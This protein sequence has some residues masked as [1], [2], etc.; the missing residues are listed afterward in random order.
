MSAVPA[1]PVPTLIV[2]G[3]G[4][5]AGELLRLVA[6]HP[7]LQLAGVSSESQAGSPVSASF[8]HLAP[9]LRDTPFI[10]Q[11]ELAGQLG[12]ERV[13]IFSAAPHVV[14]AGVVG[15]LLQAAG[16]RGT[17]V[18]VV[19][20]S[21]DFRFRRA[22]EF[23]AVYKSPHGAPQLL[24]QF[25]CALPEHLPGIPAPHVGHPG[26][27]ASA[28][29]AGLVPLLRLR[30]TEGPVY[31]SGVTGSTGAGRTPIATTHHPER[32]SNLFAY[33]PLQHRHTPEVMQICAQ[34]TG[35]SPELYFIPHS[36]PFARGIH[37]TL[38]ARL[39]APQTADQ[40][41]DSIAGFYAGCE[42]VRV[43]D[44]MPRVKDVAGSNYCHVGVA[45]SGHSVAV[46][47]TLDNL[48]KGA[49]GGAVQW[50]NRL[51]GLPETAGL[52]APAPGWI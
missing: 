43:V 10:S 16:T 25:V 38:Q 41:R 13:A 46:M 7:G 9:L 6:Q 34:L 44:G 8:P 2:G 36:G 27:F 24:P 29:L 45:A 15:A 37:M 28:M 49:A 12:G 50:M 23:Q 4:Y 18:T 3:T 33:N 48:V 35:V 5:V 22:Q 32:H 47:V 19:D 14:S 30:L 20:V 11:A 26:C 31:A 40:L 51:L 17:P 39:A 1:T 52:T 21:S 42:F